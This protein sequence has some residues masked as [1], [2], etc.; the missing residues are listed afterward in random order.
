MRSPPRR[1]TEI[2][3][4]EEHVGV[5]IMKTGWETQQDAH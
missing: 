3:E 5:K 2:Y 4:W 1:K